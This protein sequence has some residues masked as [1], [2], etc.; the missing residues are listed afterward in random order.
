MTVSDLKKK[1]AEHLNVDPKDIILR[2]N[3]VLLRDQEE[4]PDSQNYDTI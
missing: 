2:C 4:I 3:N 1:I